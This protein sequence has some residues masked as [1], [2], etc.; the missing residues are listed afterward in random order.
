MPNQYQTG[1]I[2]PALRVGK[3]LGQVLFS[4]SHPCR[5]IS[6]GSI[7]TAVRNGEKDGKPMY[8]ALRCRLPLQPGEIVAA[9]RNGEKDGKPIYKA[10]CDACEDEPPPPPCVMTLLFSLCYDNCFGG[11]FGGAGPVIGATVTVDFPNGS[12]ETGTTGS[13]GVV[14]FTKDGAQFEGDWSY[15]IEGAQ[16]A[17]IVGTAE[18]MVCG[19]SRSLDIVAGWKPEHT[20]CGPLYC[21]GCDH[22]LHPPP[23]TVYV[24]N[25]H[26]TAVLNYD[27]QYGLHWGCQSI[28][29]SNRQLD[30][31]P[32]ALNT[33]PNGTPYD[34]CGTWH[35]YTPEAIG[36]CSKHREAVTPPGFFTPVYPCVHD[37]PV[38][39]SWV[40]FYTMIECNLRTH[41]VTCDETV[42]Y[43]PFPGVSQ[44]QRIV[45][46]GSAFHCEN[47]IVPDCEPTL[48]TV[49]C[50]YMKKY[51]LDSRGAYEYIAP[52]MLGPA[53]VDCGQTPASRTWPLSTPDL[54]FNLGDIFTLTA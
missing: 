22:P 10:F 9:R 20:P 51:I 54:P 5:T 49:N 34:G 15:T 47:R 37:Q 7:V 30:E 53:L 18:D 32:D 38:Q 6:P 40:V 44:V 23:A 13:T 42:W 39:G 3:R 48:H 35:N 50:A 14:V 1:D 36:R 46:V 26:G 52:S 21:G 12:S 41:I 8:K 17:T 28:A 31:D 27:P 19:E 2:V 4:A 25:K 24:T 11:C 29:A 33:R 43:T 16:I 45:P